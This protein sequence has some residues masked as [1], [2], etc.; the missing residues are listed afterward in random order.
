MARNVEIICKYYQVRERANGEIT[1]NTFDLR[2]WML[3]VNQ[4]DFQR[5]YKEANGVKGRLE[6]LALVSREEEIYA[7]NFMRMEDV[8]TS[9]VLNIN[10]PAEHVDIDIAADEYIARNTVCLY[11]PENG[12][13]MIQCNRGSYSEKS[14]ES[15]INEFYDE[16]VCTIVPI[17]ENIDMLADSAEYMKLDVRLANIRNFVPTENTSFEKYE[18]AVSLLNQRFWN[19]DLDELIEDSKM[20]QYTLESLF[21]DHLKPELIWRFRKT[22][23]SCFNRRMVTQLLIDEYKDAQISYSDGLIAIKKLSEKYNLNFQVEI[24]TIIMDYA[25]GNMSIRPKMSYRLFNISKQYFSKAKSENIRRFV[26]CQID[27]FVMQNIL[28]ENVDYI[29]FMNKVNILNEH[30]FLQEYV[31]GKLKFFACRMVDFGRIN[32]DSRISVSFMTECINEIEKIKLNNYISL[33][34]RERYLYNYILCYFYIIQNQ[35]ENAKAAIIENLAYVKEAGA[36]YKIPLEHNLANLETIR[37]VEWFQNQC[38]YPENV[39]LLDSRFW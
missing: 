7:F 5:K 36:T 31:K 24:A 14:I 26:I 32:G 34:G 37:R 39:Y 35:Y 16:P 25:R 4:L 3:H 8:S 6:N 33:Q 13:I 22:Y 9:Y 17:F 27:L 15:Y 30:N 11:D 28:K 20:Y 18:V 1:E 38:N 23:E 12:I 21:M 29:D 19:I 2:E 10:N